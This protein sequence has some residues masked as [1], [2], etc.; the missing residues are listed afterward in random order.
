[1]QRVCVIGLGYI[2]LPTAA[3]FATHGYHVIG[4]DTNQ[5]V[6]QRVTAGDTN[7]KEPGLRTLVGAAVNSRNLAAA[8]AVPE[9][10]VFIIAVPTPI[11]ADHR[12]DLS[13]VL[14]ASKAVAGRLSRGNLVVLE[15]T[16]PPG[17]TEGSVRQILEGS[18]LQVGRDFMLAHCPERVLPGRILH[19][20]MQNDRIVGGVTPESAEAARGLYARVVEGRILV[21]DATTAEVVKLAENTYR[22]VN[23][24]LANELARVC[25]RLGIDAGEVIDLA[26]HHPRV[27]LLRPGPGVGG[28]C[29]GVDPWFLIQAAP[30]ET[31]LMQAARRIND[32]QPRL[33]L[34]MIRAMLGSAPSSAVAVLGVAYKANVDDVRESPALAVI[35]GLRRRGVEVRA[36]DTHVPG[37]RF[38]L[39]PLEEAV[40]GADLA[41]I[42]TDHDAFKDLSP[43]RLA[44]LMRRKQILDTRRCI[45]PSVWRAAGFTVAVLGSG[46]D[47]V[48]A[49]PIA[50]AP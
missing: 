37:T 12:A 13:Y 23:I 20:L 43:L 27:G 39:L 49:A 48:P 46:R 31:P 7:I 18:G 6:V 21:T 50:P 4:V 29:I 36:C 28:H 5:D 45:T 41:V 15:S 34:E 14:A 35:D 32:D 19:E 24:A 1:M 8:S 40:A 38:A 16:V 30:E 25:M 11:G 42:L 17:T 44:A 9:A 22:D 2:G 10:D 26:N 33:V 3:V 47:G